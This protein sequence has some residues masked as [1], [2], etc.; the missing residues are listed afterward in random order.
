MDVYLKKIEHGSLTAFAL[1]QGQGY[2][3]QFQTSPASTNFPQVPANLRQSYIKLHQVGLPM[4][5]IEGGWL[6]VQ[7]PSG[8]KTVLHSDADL[9]R[10]GY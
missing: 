10:L 2:R 7:L 3:K 6:E 5:L 4:K 1:H 9:N 8:K